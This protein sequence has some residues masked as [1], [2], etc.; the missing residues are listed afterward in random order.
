M[1]AIPTTS[2]ATAARDLW[3]S[4]SARSASADWHQRAL[5]YVREFAAYADAPFLVEQIREFAE[6][7]GLEEPRNAKVWGPVIQEA[8]RLKIIVPCGFAPARSS[9][10]S[11]KV[12]W[13]AA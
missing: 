13:R 3:I 8:R 11:P 5:G 10:G 4:R 9:H 12:L 1:S 7:G 6:G 2:E